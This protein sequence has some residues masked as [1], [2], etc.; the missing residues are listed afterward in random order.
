MESVISITRSILI[1][2]FYASQASFEEETDIQKL[3][4]TETL[5]DLHE[6]MQRA[7]TEIEKAISLAEEEV[8]IYITLDL[9]QLFRKIFAAEE[10]F[11]VTRGVKVNIYWLMEKDAIIFNTGLENE[12]YY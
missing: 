9:Y 1:D 3:V 2:G 6:I 11:Y 8:N 4:Y 5:T 7:F 10:I 12:L